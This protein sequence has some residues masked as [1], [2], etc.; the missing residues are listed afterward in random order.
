[1]KQHHLKH[2]LLT[3]LAI[4]GC[5]PTALAS[6]KIGDLYYNLDETTLSAEVTYLFRESSSNSSYVSGDLVIPS[7]VVYNEKEYSV[8]SIGSDAFYYCSGLT[9]VVIP[10]SV[11]SIG[12]YAFYNTDIKKAIWLTNTPPSG[13]SNVGAAINYVSNNQYSFSNQK[14][15]SFLSSKFEVDNVVYVPVRSVGAN[16]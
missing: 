16:L 11:T 7:S 1:M 2:C 9:S 5:V 12:S 8:T 6:V 4:L 13:A 3:L 15:Y 10:N 14:V